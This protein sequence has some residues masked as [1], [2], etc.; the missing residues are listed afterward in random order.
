MSYEDVVLQQEKERLAKIA[1]AEQ[2]KQQEQTNEETPKAKRKY[3]R[4]DSG[5]DSQ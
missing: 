4:R 5:S 3:T 1:E 2:S